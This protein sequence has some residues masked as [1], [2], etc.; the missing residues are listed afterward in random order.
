MMT[1]SYFL[2]IKILNNCVR[3]DYINLTKLKRCN[4]TPLQ[5]GTQYNSYISYLNQVNVFHPL[6]SKKDFN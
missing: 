4:G 2:H 1:L 3:N 5:S 6:D